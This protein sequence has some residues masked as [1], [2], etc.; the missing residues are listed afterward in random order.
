MADTELQV[1]AREGWF[2][3][4][5]RLNGESVSSLEVIDLVMRIGRSAVRMGGIGG[6]GTE[7]EHRN[8]GYARRVL[9]NS[10][11][12]MEANGFDCATLF[13]IEDFYHKFGYAVC[14]AD[15]R[16]EVRTRDA[17]RALASLSVRPFA[18]DDLPAVRDI[19]AANNA[20]LNGSIVRSDGTRWFRKGSR[21]DTG[22]EVCVF[23]NDAGAIVAYAARDTS[24]D[25]VTLCEAGARRPEY[26]ADITRWAAEYAV[27]QRVE[28]IT[29]MLPPDSLGAAYLTQIGARQT[30]SFPRNG[31]G[32][33]RILNLGRFLEKTLPEWTQR[34]SAAREIV[35][36][37]AL[38]LET[39]IGD[40]TL[41][42]TGTTLDID[43]SARA[44]GTVRLPQWRL[45][46]MAMGY[47][48]AE[49][50][51]SF[52][53]VEATGDLGLLYPLFPRRLGYMW[54]C[55]HF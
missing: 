48:G 8:K 13:G 28:N 21:Y 38:R 11:T 52:P 40:I 41:R 34:A 32:M 26:Y 17:E 1:T 6:V 5:L 25:R 22:V 4:E 35:P 44:S 49:L 47:Y 15:S 10:N 23:T 18:Q 37:T 9:E 54:A 27:Q 2:H 16:S 39:D 24:R 53:E 7:G 31:E 19:Y 3:H 43:D 33:G 51:L 20:T 36:G 30:L 46:Q 42:W 45:M 55:D 12:W 50:T 14:L 29:F